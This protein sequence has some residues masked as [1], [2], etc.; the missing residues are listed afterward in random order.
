VR[1]IRPFRSSWNTAA[2]YHPLTV[3]LQGLAT[4]AAGQE[5]G[6]DADGIREWMVPPVCTRCGS[7][8]GVCMRYTTLNMKESAWGCD[9]C[10]GMLPGYSGTAE[11]SKQS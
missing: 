5:W 8:V 7:T 2:P 11:L 9:T 6:D 10:V 4:R 1:D 3:G